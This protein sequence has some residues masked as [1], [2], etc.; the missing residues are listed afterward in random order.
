M[1]QTM[2]AAKTGTTVTPDGQRR[3]VRQ[4]VTTAHAGHEIVERY[5]H[6]WA[7]IRPDYAV[8]DGEALE[9]AV[10]TEE[11]PV[12]GRVRALLQLDV[13]ASTQEICDALDERLAAA[14]GPETV[15]VRTL[16]DR[17]EVYVPVDGPAA[18]QGDDT[19][20]GDVDEAVERA[21]IRAWAAGQG[22]DVSPRGKIP[23]AVVEQY[24]AAHPEG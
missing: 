14:D 5:P 15:D 21:R 24:R 20:T 18:P 8:D 16:A 1:Q 9:A 19:Q 13:D 6:L 10:N 17:A 3:I 4:G 12:R 22:I 23:T 11:D 2:I 7:P